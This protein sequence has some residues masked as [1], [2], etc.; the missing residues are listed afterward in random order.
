VSE[1]WD[2]PVVF[3]TMVQ[4]LE[5][6][7]RGGTRG[8]R[9]MHQLANSVL[10]FDEIQTLPIKCVHLFNNAV[11]FLT[12]Q[13]NS[14]I[15]FCSAT[16]PLLGQVDAAKGAVRLHPDAELMPD[17][18]G[19]FRDL[20][21]VR[22]TYGRKERT[23]LQIA[24]L[25]AEHMR[26][27]GSCLVIANTKASA[28]E[29]YRHNAEFV[30]EEARF[31]LSTDLCPAH[32]ADLLGFKGST[33]PEEKTI[34]GRLR[35]DLP[36][37]CVSTQ[38]MEAG[39]DADF[40]FVIRFLAG[41]DAIAQAA[42]RGNRHAKRRTRHGAPAI[43]RVYVVRPDM[44]RLGSL[45]EIQKG[46]EVTRR[47]FDEYS[48]DPARFG[49]DLIGPEAVELY[50]RY[51]FFERQDEMDYWLSDDD[52]ATLGQSSET[53][54]N[55][56]SEN[57]KAVNDLSPPGSSLFHRQAFSAAGSIFRAIDAPTEGVVVPYGSEGRRLIDALLGSGDDLKRQYQLVWVA[58]RY[59]VNVYPH[60]MAR[61]LED[62][63]VRPVSDHSRIHVLIDDRY[64]SP[65]LGL[66][67]ELDDDW[68]IESWL[69]H[70]DG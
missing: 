59:T 42:G 11:N 18:A 51:Y 70:G 55:L 6:V 39:I 4:F 50:Y 62:Q 56:L 48:Q 54:L 20:R 25:A 8:A 52:A 28:R 46:Q 61:L 2:A 36:T 41:I 57:A 68:R 9:R 13:C 37:L 32:R 64:Y 53:L 60:T 1:K 26:R 65:R 31:Y 14:T 47:I 35:M 22:V 43:G 45:S 7:F 44:E 10:I 40:A 15:I 38:V 49:H 27:E 63:A 19:L 24:R 21:R 23:H 58:Q 5:T 30:P 12:E 67:T 34:L 16:Q 66:N 29:V 69:V 3:T 33:A 17:V